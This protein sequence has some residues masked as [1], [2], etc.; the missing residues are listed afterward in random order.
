MKIN[1]IS[2]IQ[3]IA[4][5]FIPYKFYIWKIEKTKSLNPMSES[6]IRTMNVPYN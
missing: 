2:V 1:I 5:K 3:F 6:S 4:L